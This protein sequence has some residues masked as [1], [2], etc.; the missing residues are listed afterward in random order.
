MQ[1]RFSVEPTLI[2]GGAGIFDVVADEKLIYRKH[3]TGR[4]PVHDEVLSKLA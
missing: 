4:F 3:Q 2:S 1:Q